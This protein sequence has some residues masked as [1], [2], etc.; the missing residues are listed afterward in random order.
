[1]NKTTKHE[2][3]QNGAEKDLD[4]QVLPLK[5]AAL[6]LRSLNHPVRQQILAI[7]HRQE[8]VTVTALYMQLRIE[9][10]VASL[11]LGILRR[12]GFVATR[13]QGR[14]VYYSVN[15]HRLS[16]VHLFIRELTGQA[17]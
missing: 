17:A 3:H 15:Y 12:A 1:M 2:A 9:Q 16:T 4:L 13:R 5:K 8:R 14:F 6:V 7:L 10:S 11:Q